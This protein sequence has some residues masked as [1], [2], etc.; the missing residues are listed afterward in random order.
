MS[1]T[2]LMKI[3][4]KQRKHLVLPGLMI[5]VINKANSLTMLIIAVKM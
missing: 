2:V 4:H 3:D 1:C 5:K